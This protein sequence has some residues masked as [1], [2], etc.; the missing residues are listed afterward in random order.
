[1]T[2]AVPIGLDASQR[3]AIEGLVI[4]AR[5][6]LENDLAAQ[7]EGR[8]GIHPDG[9]IEDEAALPDDT[10]DKITRRDLMQIVAHLRT[11]GEDPPGAV[12]RL[13]REAA[14]THLNRLVAIRIAEAIGLL[15]ESLA[16]GPQSRGFKDLGEIMPMLAGDY[17]AYLRLCGDELAADTPALFDPRN[18][19]LALEPS[20]A[21]FD[22]L[23]A[24]VADPAATEIWLAPD[25]LGWAYQFFNTGDERREMREA[26]APRN[27]REL[28]VR[29]QFF[30]PR[31]VVD[32]L[33]Q[34]TI[35]RR[36]IESDPASPL[37]S[38]LP[39]LVDPP[40]QPGPPLD[41]ERVKCLDPACGSGHFLLGCYDVLERAW[42]LAGVS[43]S[44]S[45]PKIVASL[46]GVDIDARCAQV[47]SAAI[48]LR[49]RRHCRHLPLPRPNIVTAR[50]LPGGGRW[51][52]LPT[53]S[54]PPASGASSTASAKSWPTPHCW[55]RC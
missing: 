22:D 6:L 16:A 51:H 52:C 34:N 33:V 28:A 29:N 11:L 3:T 30:T 15:P 32:F 17:R 21:A 26:S 5:V 42:E 4:R 1:M 37:L 40:S 31:Y 2:I 47:A 50:G 18:P 8:F 39:L 12:A 48:V 9:T 41:L 55:A 10:T 46:W 36:L 23:I 24:L 13:L 53:W 7:L 45:A 35:G 14:F 44:E 54:S 25:T 19:L 27:S 43:P 20:T 38:E 49:A